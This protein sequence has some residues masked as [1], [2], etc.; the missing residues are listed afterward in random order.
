MLKLAVF[1]AKCILNTREAVGFGGFI[2]F[3]VVSLSLSRLFLFAPFVALIELGFELLQL[4]LTSFLLH[5]DAVL[6]YHLEL[7]FLFVHPLHPRVRFDDETSG[8]VDED[9]V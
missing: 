3:F 1:E 6:G 8:D 2:T 7:L 4:L 5:L 9:E